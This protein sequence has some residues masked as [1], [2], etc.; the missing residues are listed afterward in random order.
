MTYLRILT[1]VRVLFCFLAQPL[2]I[3]SS[4]VLDEIVLQVLGRWRDGALERWGDG[5]LVLLQRSNAQMPH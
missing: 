3:V 1:G 4:E 2:L 5:G